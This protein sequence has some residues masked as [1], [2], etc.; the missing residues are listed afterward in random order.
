MNPDLLSHR[1]KYQLQQDAC[2]FLSWLLYETHEVINDSKSKYCLTYYK[3]DIMEMS[4]NYDK[5]G[6]SINILSHIFLVILLL[7]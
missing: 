4:C 6:R 7:E 5:Y 3:V 2:E 1:S